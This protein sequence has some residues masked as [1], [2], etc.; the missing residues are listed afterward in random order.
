MTE[1]DLAPITEE[2][3]TEVEDDD[4]P[5]LDLCKGK[6]SLCLRRKSRKAEGNNKRE[7][8]TLAHMQGTGL[9]A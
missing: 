3:V 9:H 2:T 1:M 5:I 8:E 7:D 6:A 4:E